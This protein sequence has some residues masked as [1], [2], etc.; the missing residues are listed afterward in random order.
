M[1]DTR[2]SAP[3]GDCRRAVTA[4]NASGAMGLGGPAINSVAF[5][6]IAHPMP[7]VGRYVYRRVVCDTGDGQPRNRRMPE[8]GDSSLM[9][10][11]ISW[12]LRGIAV[13][14]MT[15]GMPAV[16][17]ERRLPVRYLE[18]SRSTE[19]CRRQTTRTVSR[20]SETTTGYQAFW[21]RVARH[22]GLSEAA[23][24]IG[25]RAS[26]LSAFEKGGENNLSADQITALV[27]Y[28]ESIPVPEPDIPEILDDEDKT[29]E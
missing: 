3:F 21:M 27:A 1:Q 15:W 10:R 26:A 24:Q 29:P 22:V 18:R 5:D 4:W 2:R 19:E 13:M 6:R 11:R 25:V 28:L 8:R 23:K 14:R 9:S 16:V 17:A 7:G 12:S 20:M